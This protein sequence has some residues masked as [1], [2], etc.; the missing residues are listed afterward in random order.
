MLAAGINDGFVELIKEYWYVTVAIVL[1]L[2]LLLIAIWIVATRVIRQ[3]KENSDVNR[4]RRK[5]QSKMEMQAAISRQEADSAQEVNLQPN[6]KA[7]RQVKEET[8]SMRSTP[9]PIPAEKAAEQTTDDDEEIG[10]ILKGKMATTKA[11]VTAEENKTEE[12]QKMAK[13]DAKEVAKAEEKKV[14]EPVEEPAKAEEKLAEDKAVKAVYRVSYDKEAKEWLIKKDGAQRVIRRCRTKAEA[15]ELANQFAENQDLSL[16]VHKKDGKF[17][18]KTIY[19][20]MISTDKG[21][22]GDKKTK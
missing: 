7:D 19:T 6:V 4:A 17:Q 16:S 22:K 12:E 18:K 15:L 5:E 1:I 3:V 10:I 13:A 20:K 14:A 9:A 11:A 8:L 21:D 2:L